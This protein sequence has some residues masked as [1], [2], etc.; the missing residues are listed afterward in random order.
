METPT[1]QELYDS[2]LNDMRSKF[3]ISTILGKVVLNTIALVQAAKLKIIYTTIAFRYKNI[4]VDTADSAKRGGTL[5]RF[6]LVKLG[7]Q[8]FSAVAGVYTA[9][10]TGTIGAVISKETTYK[11]LSGSKNPDKLFVLDTDFTFTSTSGTI[12]LRALDLGSDASLIVADELQVTSPLANVD[13][14]AFIASVTTTATDSESYEEY[15]QAVIA[16]Y[17][18]EAQGGARTD[19][20]LW[21]Q[22]ATGVREVYP[23]A[24]ENFVGE[25]N[26]YVEALQADSTD[27]N[28]TPSASLLTDVEAVVELD[29]DTTKSI[30]ERGR[31]PISAFDIH[32]LTVTPLPVDVVITDLSDTSLLSAISTAMETFLY[33]VRP[34]IAGADTIN[35]KNKGKLYI[36]DVFNVVRSVIGVTATFTDITMDVDSVTYTLYEFLDGDIPYINSVTNV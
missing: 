13:S 35:D 10:V 36:S 21:S 7:R 1:F 32:Y 24:K 25:I 14:F 5:E 17:Q 27:G 29:P 3:G 18:L 23:Y 31:R 26:L 6:G 28:G 33:D 22:D 8:P 30:Y 9:T 15:R 19:Y 11:S 16:S 4:F 12:T 34:Y 2:I 20:R